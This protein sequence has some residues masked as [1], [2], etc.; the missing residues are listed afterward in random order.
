MQYWVRRYG[1]GLL[2]ALSV[3]VLSTL[4]QARDLAM[5]P[6]DMIAVELATVGVDRAGGAPV[7]LL[8][9]PDSGDVVPIHIGF[10]EA[11]AIL[12]EQHGVPVPRP[13]THDLVGSILQGLDA[14]LERVF[15]DNLADGIYYG[16]LELSVAG[17]DAPVHVDTRPSD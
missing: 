6:E 8:R 17:Q 2:V 12:M 13:Q 9:E 3:G 14:T 1:I 10:A 5:D 11:R 15:V 16:M 4:A 7:V